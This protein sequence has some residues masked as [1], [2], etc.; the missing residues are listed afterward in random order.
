MPRILL[1]EDNEMNR[2]M[3]SRRL[4]RHGFE[5]AIAQDGPHGISAARSSSFDLILMDLSLPGI[6]GWE[7]S[8]FLKADPTTWSVPIIALTAHAMNG[9]RERAIEAG[10]DD[11]DT[12]PID[13][14]RLMAKIE[15]ILRRASPPMPA[16]TLE[17]PAEEGPDA[18]SQLRH[19]LIAPLNR[20]LGY[21]ELLIEDANSQ[22]WV[23]RVES[24]RSIRNL[25]KEALNAIDR[26]LSQHRT[27]DRTPD[28]AAL[29]T[30][31]LPPSKAILRSCEAL[32]AA[33]SEIPA[34]T[35]FHEDL[36]RVRQDSV[37]LIQL[38]QGKTAD[39]V[40]AP[41]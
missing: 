27:P 15:A 30:A 31:A 12:K 26:V 7:A 33:S 20:I 9:D 2:D 24:L 38:I 41:L 14:P 36:A 19:D 1:V 23:R 3:L 28:L 32:D 39:L 17:P 4:A 5:V 35:E 13:F 40:R 6:D 11:Y 21:C 22:G 18:S 29:A 25:G 34:R 8:R 10:C 16:Q 37:L